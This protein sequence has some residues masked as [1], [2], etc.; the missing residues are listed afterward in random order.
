MKLAKFQKDF[1]KAALSEG[2]DASILTTPR[3]NGKSTFGGALA[4][5]ALFDD[6]ATGSPQVPIVATTVGQAVR[7]CYG[8][9]LSMIKADPELID[10]ALI[11][12]GATNPKV[13]VPFNDGSMFPIANDPDGLMGLDPSLA[14]VDEIGFQPPESWSALRQASGKRERSLIVGVGTAGFDD[15]NAL[16]MLRKTLTEGG[17]IA[18]LVYQEYSASKATSLTD[19][20]VWRKA[21]PAMAAGFLRPSALESEIKELPEALFRI[22]RLN[23]FGV[24]GVE[25]WLGQDGEM[26]W[27]AL[28]KPYQFVAGAE[29]WIGLDVGIKR[30]STAVVMVQRD[31]KAELHADCRLWVPSDNNPVDVTDVM[32]YLRDMAKLYDVQAISFDPRFFDVPA[33][34]LGDEGLPLIEVDQSPERM[35]PI[36]GSLLELIK[37][38]EIHHNGDEALATHVLNAVP[39]FNDRGFTLAKSKAKGRID[40]VVALALAVDRAMRQPVPV[41]GWFIR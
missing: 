7:S 22:F 6:D 4:V 18:G 8:V 21:N 41:G 33:K 26:M 19:R 32:N 9:A 28:R 15:E 25:S 23:Q 34:M 11:Y 2:V 29:T 38:H 20:R 30:D 31:D 39:R 10:R 37:R 35:T 16:A 40:A 36:V 3:G 13:V 24:R 1:L 14:I 27:N 5:W 17:S 12:S